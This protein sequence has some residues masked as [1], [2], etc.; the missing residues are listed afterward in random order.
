MKKRE[1]EFVE[2][3]QVFDDDNNGL[4]YGVNWLDKNNDIA[5]CEWFKTK[6]ERLNA[7]KGCFGVQ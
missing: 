3:S 5:D 2:A 6:K 4:I 1:Y 7:V